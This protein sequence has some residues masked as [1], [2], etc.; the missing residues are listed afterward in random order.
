MTFPKPTKYKVKTGRKTKREKKYQDSS[1]K[2]EFNT[3]QRNAREASYYAKCGYDYALKKF[4]EF[5]EEQEQL[6]QMYLKAHPPEGPQN[7][8]QD[9]EDYLIK[10]IGRSRYYRYGLKDVIFNKKYPEFCS[11]ET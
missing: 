6:H 1:L 7:I 2:L 3:G 10:H 9:V 5:S 4:R 8:A 11:G